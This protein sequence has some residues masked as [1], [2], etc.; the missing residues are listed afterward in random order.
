[1]VETFIFLMINRS[2]EQSYE[3]TFLH[4]QNTKIYY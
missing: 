3:V 4:L 1:M 2:V